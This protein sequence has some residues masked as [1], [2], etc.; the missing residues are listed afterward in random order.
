MEQLVEVDDNFYMKPTLKIIFISYFL[1][2]V[3]SFK[4]DSY[5]DFDHL[6]HKYIIRI[7]NPTAPCKIHWTI[8]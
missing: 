3:R 6:S 8:S 7:K 4:D 5:N 2:F 1:P